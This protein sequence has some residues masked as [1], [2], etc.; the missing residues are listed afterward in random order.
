MKMPESKLS[1]QAAYQRRRRAKQRPVTFFPAD[2]ARLDQAINDSGAGVQEWLN[3]AIQQR[4]DREGKLKEMVA[5]ALDRFG[6]RCFWNVN[7]RQSLWLLVPLVA[8]RLRKYGG[9]EGLALAAELEALAPEDCQW[10]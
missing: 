9:M 8:T 3:L 2:R 5:T 4:A 6:P 10:H 7:T 1:P